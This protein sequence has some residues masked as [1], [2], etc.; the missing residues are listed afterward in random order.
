MNLII[1]LI[2]TGLGGYIAWNTSSIGARFIGMF[3]CIIGIAVVISQIKN[4]WKKDLEE[5]A[6]ELLDEVAAL[7]EKLSHVNHALLDKAEKKKKVL[8]TP[9]NVGQVRKD[10][11]VEVRDRRHE[12]G[13]KMEVHDHLPRRL[14]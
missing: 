3:T 11:K 7:Q 6:V 1:G 13:T 14:R 4:F 9:Y 5:E 8:E 10:G 2:L 12:G